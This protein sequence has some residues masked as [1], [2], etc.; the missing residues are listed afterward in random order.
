MPK[1]YDVLCAGLIVADLVASPIAQLPRAGELAAIENI[2]LACGGCAVNVAINL[3]KLGLKTVLAGKIGDDCFGNAVVEELAHKGLGTG[4]IRSSRTQPTSTT[5]I[6]NVKG[7]DR[8]YVHSEGANAAFG[9]EDIDLQMI[10]D[11]K[12]FYVG[13]LL[14]MKS[15]DCDSLLPLFQYARQQG[16]MTV[17]DVVVPSGASPGLA[18][19]ARLLPYTDLFLPNEDEGS[20]ITGEHDAEKQAR[21]FI[22]LGAKGVIIT[23]GGAGS[24]AML[25]HTAVIAGAYPVQAVDSS[26]GGDAYT[27]GIIYGE[28]QGWQLRD[29]I[30]FASAM[31]ASACLSRGCTSSTFTLAEARQF[32]QE[33]QL[34]IR[35]Q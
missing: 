34:D 17:L 18:G 4:Q 1:K 32:L 9:A 10:A 31:G 6:L 19:L 21:I 13:G 5:F 8:R 24:I 15:L 16:T 7:D 27:S 25:E 11:S 29:K 22:G 12:V 2:S 14:A 28:L 23:R 33:H 3:S 20:M 26:G 35:E 30:A